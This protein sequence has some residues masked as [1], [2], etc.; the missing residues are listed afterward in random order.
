METTKQAFLN[1]ESQEKLRNIIRKIAELNERI[2]QGMN[3]SDN[4]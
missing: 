3:A 2:E 4:K 1:P